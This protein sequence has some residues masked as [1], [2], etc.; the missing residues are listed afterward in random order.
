MGVHPVKVKWFILLAA[1]V[2]PPSHTPHTHTQELL[3]FSPW[4]SCHLFF[5]PVLLTVFSLLSFLMW[6]LLFQTC[7]GPVY[8]R[9]HLSDW[10]QLLEQVTFKVPEQPDS[11]F[12]VCCLADT[13]VLTRCCLATNLRLSTM[14]CVTVTESILKTQWTRQGN[15]LKEILTWLCAS[16]GSVSGFVP[17]LQ[18]CGLSVQCAPL[19]QMRSKQW[20][21]SWIWPTLTK[22][23]IVSS[24]THFPTW[25]RHS[26]NRTFV[27][28]F[29]ILG[30]Y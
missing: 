22:Q 6:R 14:S 9:L 18:D 15:Q 13:V 10:K 2:F 5:L 27:T 19:L 21:T 20:G 7:T 26:D 8:S 17:S 1:C 28:I 24:K 25:K 23:W 29:C 11:C 3:S 16:H 30:W 12:H 4:N